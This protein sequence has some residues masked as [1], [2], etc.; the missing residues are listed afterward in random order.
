LTSLPGPKLGRFEQAIAQIGSLLS[1]Q[2]TSYSPFVLAKRERVTQLRKEVQAA[3]QA[4]AVGG[5]SLFGLRANRSIRNLLEALSNFSH[6]RYEETADET[7]VRCLRTIQSNLEERCRDLLRCRQRLSHMKDAILPLTQVNPPAAPLRKD[8]AASNEMLHLQMTLV[9]T[10]TRA[11]VGTLLPKNNPNIQ[12]AACELVDRLQEKDWA[13]LEEVLQTLVIQ[14]SGGLIPICIQS[15][16]LGRDLVLP[17]VE[18]GSAFLGSLVRFNGVFD[19]LRDVQK[20]QQSEEAFEKLL[21][22]AEPSLGGADSEER[23]YLIVPKKKDL[24]TTVLRTKSKM[25]DVE[26]ISL[27]ESSSEWLVIRERNCLRIQDLQELLSMCREAYTQLSGHI[28]TSPHAR[29]D[30]QEW[31]PLE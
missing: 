24:Q 25:N 7:A 20:A 2:A 21:A 9:P 4:C 28:G 15:N 29:F 18:Q 12:S 23:V 19:A 22:P 5:F 16:D 30:V 27:P 10:S 11:A 3:Y 31:L 6:E 26:W 1:N 8:P 17:L 14:P 13:R